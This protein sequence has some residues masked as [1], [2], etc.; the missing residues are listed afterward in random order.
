MT[1]TASEKVRLGVFVIAGSLF[2]LAA[3]YLIGNNQNL[4]RKSFTINTVFTNVNGLQKGNNVRFAGIN[5]GTVKAMEMESDTAIRIYMVIEEK[6][7]G[8]IRKDA[9]ATIGS[10]GL[11]G[12]MIV[13]II[14]GTGSTETI[15]DGDQIVSYTRIGTEDMLNT[16]STTNENAAMLMADLLK[17][18]R[19]LTQGKGTLGRLLNDTV[20]ATDL[21]QTLVNLKQASYRTNHVFSQLDG[22]IKDIRQKENVAGILLQDTLAGKKVKNIITN[23]EAS[24]TGMNDM[25]QNLNDVVLELRDG[26]GPLNYIATDTLLVRQ[27]EATM[28]NIEEGT[29]RFNENMEALK[30]NFLFRGYFRKQEKQQ[31]RK[32]K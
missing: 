28:H 25:V 27:L 8:F 1:K 20:M 10:D 4:F 32:I 26:K 22:M 19:S 9:I 13:N 6:M 12:N 18:T 24:S 7:L 14:P 2:L 17:I 3:A 23:L 11:V 21:Q 15:R 5:V 16:L 30:H 31:N 29:G